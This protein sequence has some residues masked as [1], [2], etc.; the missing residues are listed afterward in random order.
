M[1]ANRVKHDNGK[2]AIVV[3]AVLAVV[4]IAAAVAICY[5]KLRSTYLEQCVVDDLNTQVEI[6]SGKLVKADVIA[7]IFGIRNGTNLALLDL[8]RKREEALKRVPTLKSI[9]ITRE[10]PNRIVIR[11]EERS[12]VARMNVHGYRKVT[13]KVVDS[14]GV[15]FICRR[16]T[17]MLPTIR[18]PQAP[19]T[20]VGKRLS[21]RAMAALAMLETCHDPRFQDL[22]ILE[23]DVSKPDF[24][25]ATLGDYSRAKI[26]WEGMDDL[27]PQSRARLVTQLSHLVAA[28]NS[29][30]TNETVIWNVT[31]PKVVFA[32]AKGSLQ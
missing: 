26:A 1:K 15:V 20:L 22:G 11:A 13:G 28:I 29:K 25:V 19:G 12:P 4:A 2:R 30:I 31:M 9:T 23:I 16:G 24:L 27:T 21:N 14:D 32:D 5:N 8:E 3:L 7:E 18:E 17:D 10:M 6:T